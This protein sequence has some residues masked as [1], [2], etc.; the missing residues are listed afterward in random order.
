[1]AL[2]E[3]AFHTGVGDKI[4]YCCRLLRKA[5]RQQARM[6]VAG[7]AETLTRLDQA[8]WL[9]DVRSFIPHR[10]LAAGQ[11]VPPALLRTPI[12]LMEPGARPPVQGILLNLGPAA[13]PKFESYE[14][15]IEV[16]GLD[17]ADRLAARRRWRAY[18]AQ[19]LRI[20]HHA[21]EGQ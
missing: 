20:T 9:F 21:Q 18:E 13:V 5:Y 19:G 14:R 8:L 15:L 16:V 6:V 12:W 1:M 10:R 11:A 2:S 4:G 3:V 7:D 17:E